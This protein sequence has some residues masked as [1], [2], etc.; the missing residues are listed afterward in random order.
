MLVGASNCQI[1]SA[2]AGHERDGSLGEE[3]KQERSFLFSDA[4]RP[5][6]HP[7]PTSSR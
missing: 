4:S 3:R 1:T 7:S 5:P 6:S 2:E